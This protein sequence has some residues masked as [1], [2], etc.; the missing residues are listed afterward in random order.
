MIPRR[1]CFLLACLLIGAPAWAQQQGQPTVPEHNLQSFEPPSLPMPNDYRAGSGEPGEDYWQQRADYDIDVTLEPETNRIEGSETIT[2][3]NNS[4]HDL[5]RLWVQLDQNLFDP[6]SRGARI[7][8]PD[9]RFSGAFE[10]GGYDISN[11]AVETE[12]GRYE[13]EYLIDGTKMRITLD[14]PLPANGGQ[15][16]L[17]LDFGF[18]I[19]EYG[20]D[21]MGRYDAE[22]GTVYELAQW[23]PRMYTFDDV[24]G[25]NV[26]PYLGQG[27]YYLE[28]GTF[29]LD[30]TVPR[31]MIVGAT[32]ELLNE[33]EVLTSEQR[34]RID[35][36]RQSDETVTIIGQNEVGDDATRPDGSGPLTWRFRAENVRDVAWAASASF[37]W[38]AARAE[39]GD[40]SPALAQSLYPQEGIGTENNPGWER[41]TQYTKHSIEFYSDMWEPYPYPVAINVAGVVA[42]MEYPQI[43]FCGVERRGRSLFGVTDHEFGHEWFP[44]MVGSDERRHAWMDE[45]LNTFQ[46]MYSAQ[47]FY[48]D[49]AFNLQRQARGMAQQMQSPHADQPIMTYADRIRGQA[50][51]LLA[52]LKPGYGLVL[53]REYVLGHERFDSA[54]REYVDRWTYKHPQPA[55]FFRTMED[56][57]GEDLDWFWRGWFYSTDR[58]DQAI[59]NVEVEN[60]TTTVT[61]AN[62]E[63]LMMPATL[64]VTYE[65]GTTERKQ[66]PVEAFYTSDTFPLVIPRAVERIRLD[67]EGILPDIDLSNN[68]WRA[69]KGVMQPG[70]GR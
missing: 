44:M 54:F 35:E 37:I 1:L 62:Q 29:E 43:V 47:A 25:W 66:I 32:G 31:D 17:S 3:T 28:Y 65:D 14:E 7:T 13:P 24:N 46:N 16:E 52:Y 40:G 45:G 57:A 59:E 21:R 64:R 53:L 2:Y 48:G 70:G 50:L 9:E 11:V 22:Q 42:G 20:A 58:F 60:D 15:L 69:G 18:T 33:Q 61:V 6:E 23:Y 51:G 5:E 8:T 68:A 39:T 63:D 55:D 27:E 26:L 36:A 10:G 30:I 56:V 67:P 12:Q 49:Q 41:S 38:D 4:P 34:Q 19:P